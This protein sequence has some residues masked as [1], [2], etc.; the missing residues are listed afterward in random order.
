MFNLIMRAFD[1][2]SG[3]GTIGVG[4]VFEYTD[5]RI[6]AQFRQGEDILLDR[7]TALPCLF[8][9]EGLGDRLRTSVKSTDRV[10]WVEMSLLNS[11]LMLRF[12][13]S[14]TG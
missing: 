13:Q 4:R 8:M 14:R 12:L 6:A 5:A 11:A 10:A 2:A 3:R 1:W 9:G 7:L